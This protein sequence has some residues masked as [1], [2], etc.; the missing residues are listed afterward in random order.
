MESKY[1]VSIMGGT[2]KHAHLIMDYQDGYFGY[3]DPH[4]TRPVISEY[5]KVS[6]YISEYRS[7]LLWIR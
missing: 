7:K 2:P 5:A 3:L 4:T 6:E 1:F